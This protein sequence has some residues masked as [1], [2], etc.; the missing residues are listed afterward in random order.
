MKRTALP[1]LFA[2]LSGVLCLGRS[3]SGGDAAPAIKGVRRLWESLGE[4][5]SLQVSRAVITNRG[6]C[7]EY[8][9][10]NGSRGTSE[11]FAVYKTDKD[12]VYVDNSWIW[13]QVCITGKI[14]QRR[15]GKDVTEA[16]GAALREEQPVAPR[17][18]PASS[19]P[20]A[21]AVAI[22]TAP[23]AQSA[24]PRALVETVALTSKVPVA[25]VTTRP[26]APAQTTCEAPPAVAKSAIAREAVS[27]VAPTPVAASRANQ[28]AEPARV[29]TVVLTVQAPR[30]NDHA[31]GWRANTGPCGDPDSVR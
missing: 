2:L 30:G 25:T 21:A 16:V 11:G 15:D 18:Q 27:V 28:P 4:P 8:R 29:E 6:V 24:T 23:A 14:G 20:P 12:L 19:A 22:A 31:C 26:V 1:L 9:R 7:L 5:D 17:S 10:R 13:D 3:A